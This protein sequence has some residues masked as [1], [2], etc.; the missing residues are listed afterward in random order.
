MGNDYTLKNIIEVLYKG[1]TIKLS[2]EEF[3]MDGV[4]TS[5]H[6]FSGDNIFDQYIQCVRCGNW[7][8]RRESEVVYYMNLGDNVNRFACLE[9]YP[10]L[11]REYETKVYHNK[12]IKGRLDKLLFVNT[13]MVINSDY[14][15][16]SVFFND[17]RYCFFTRIKTEGYGKEKTVHL[18]HFIANNT[19]HVG[20][21]IGNIYPLNYRLNL[22]KRNKNPYEWIKEE[23]VSK[24]I[25]TDKWNQLI[26]YFAHCY[27]LTSSEYKDF[28]YW[29]YDN[30]RRIKDIERDG[31]ITSLELW[32]MS[33]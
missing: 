12:L 31:N 23:A 21:I 10:S 7:V 13:R 3:Y 22:S 24:Q 30:P 25:C 8:N 32:R 4:L 16:D 20:R 17:Y 26:K 15:T 14:E 28:V 2:K 1:K 19:G 5:T 27:G 29:C 6:Y 11:K 33:Q 9:C 18:D